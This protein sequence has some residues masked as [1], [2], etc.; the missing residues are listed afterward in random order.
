ML[1]KIYEII[2]DKKSFIYYN[3]C[4]AYKDYKLSL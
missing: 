2:K 3:M 4:C 1:Y